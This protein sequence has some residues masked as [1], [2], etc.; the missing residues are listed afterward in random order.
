LA[1]SQPGVTVAAPDPATDADLQLVHEA[2]YIS[3]VEAISRWAEHPDAR[4]GLEENQQRIARM[5]GLGIEDN[6]VFPG[7]PEASAL[8]A[9]ATL[10]AARA[11]W[12]G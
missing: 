4:G 12:T 1:W 2:R 10:A 5:F 9:G 8:V 11:V 7:M 3:A 6:P